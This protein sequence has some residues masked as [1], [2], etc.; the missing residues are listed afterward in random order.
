MVVRLRPCSPSA[1]VAA[2]LRLGRHSR[3]PGCAAWRP[4][5]RRALP[6]QVCASHPPVLSPPSS[7]L[8]SGPC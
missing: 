3:P 2:P 5:A 6:P 7:P 8:H 4:P 1:A